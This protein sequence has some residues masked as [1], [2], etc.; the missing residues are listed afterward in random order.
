MAHCLEGENIATLCLASSGI[1]ANLLPRGTTVHTGL[2]PPLDIT[3]GSHLGINSQSAKAD[4]LRQ[5]RVILW[6]EAPMLSATALGVIDVSLRDLMGN[7]RLFG[8]KIMVLGGDFRQILPVIPHGSEAQQL[9]KCLK[10]SSL[11]KHFT[12]LRLTKNV[13]AEPGQAEFC[14]WL[15]QLREG[16]LPATDDEIEILAQCISQ[17]NFCQLISTWHS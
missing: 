15:L 10:R 7:N 11:W 4:K 17:A 6:D 1:A 2:S 3:E 16:K 14:D 5:A 13:R 8:G 9:S 12:T